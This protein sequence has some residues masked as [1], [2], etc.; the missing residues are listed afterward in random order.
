VSTHT[1]KRQRP[2]ATQPSQLWQYR[3]ARNQLVFSG[4]EQVEKSRRK[5]GNL[6]VAM[7]GQARALHMHM[8]GTKKWCR[9][10]TLLRE[11]EMM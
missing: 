8:R 3:L 4:E 11:G 10:E 9:K 7:V 1:K 2:P 6:D 5:R